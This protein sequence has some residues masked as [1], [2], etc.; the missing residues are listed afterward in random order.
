MKFKYILLLLALFCS[1]GAFAQNDCKSKECKQ[2]KKWMQKKEW[3]NGFKAA[4][5]KSVNPVEFKAQYQKNKALW[6]KVFTFLAT[7]DLN[8]LPNG[9]TDIEKGRAWV[10]VSEYTPRTADKVKV[11]SHRKFIDLQYTLTGNEKMGL[12]RDEQPGV[13]MDYNDKRE[14]A[15][16]TS[17]KIDYYKAGPET[18]FLF[19]PA[20]LHQP[21]VLDGE[22]VKSKKIVVKIEYA[23]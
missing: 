3:A 13:L 15:F 20:D 11:E 17:D 14:V 7:N 6:D 23:N 16:W 12:A 4:P 18:F 5:D 8:S 22:P 1:M 21:S 2:A 9:T 19:F 10:T